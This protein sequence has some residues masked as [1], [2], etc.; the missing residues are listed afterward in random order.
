MLI[1]EQAAQ[2]RILVAKDKTGQ[3]A[4]SVQSS[5]DESKTQ[6]N[7]L[8]KKNKIF[9]KQNKLKEPVNVVIIFKALGIERDQEIAELVAAEE[10]TLALFAPTLFECQSLEIYSQAQAIKYLEKMIMRLTNPWT[11]NPVAS[12]FQSRQP[13][14]R[15]QEVH[16]W[17]LNTLLVNVQVKDWNF[18]EK[19]VFLGL[20]VRRLLLAKQGIVKEDDRDYYG[21][22]RLQLAGDL[23]SLLFEEHFKNFNDELKRLLLKK[24][25]KTRTK[26]LDILSEM[27]ALQNRI[28]TGMEGAI[29]TGNWCLKRFKMDRKGITEILSRLS[30]ISA[31][32][33]MTRIKSHFEKT[34]KVSGPRALQG[35]QWGMLCPSDTPEG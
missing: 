24:K 15:E 14:N 13:R 19:A 21:N 35:S 27:N 31:L 28:T 30:Y 25:D 3:F 1:Q 5:S 6:T 20:M 33:M 2:N 34:M 22:K 26:P 23:I 7:L 17:L 32:G 29:Q 12:R 10:T 4:C 16:D 9:L 11:V 18:Y 8:Q